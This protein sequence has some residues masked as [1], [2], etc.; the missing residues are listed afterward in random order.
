MGE[1]WDKKKTVGD[2]LEYLLTRVWKAG[3]RGNKIVVILFVN[4]GYS[5]ASGD[6]QLFPFPSFY[7]MPTSYTA[8]ILDIHPLTF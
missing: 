1:I 3:E 4:K 8:L 7:D 5:G 2:I 6:H